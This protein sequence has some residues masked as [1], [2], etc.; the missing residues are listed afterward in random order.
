VLLTVALKGDLVRLSTS[1][2]TEKSST[3]LDSPPPLVFWIVRSSSVH[4]LELKSH[5]M[6][7]RNKVKP[8]SLEDAQRK[9]TYSLKVRAELKSRYTITRKTGRHVRVGVANVDNALEIEEVEP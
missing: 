6:T 3:S 2:V 9:K 5:Y 7:V 4:P 1:R 8:Y